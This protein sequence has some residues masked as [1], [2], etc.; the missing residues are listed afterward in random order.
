M[1]IIGPDHGHLI[2]DVEDQGQDQVTE[3][4]G[5]QNPERDKGHLK[6]HHKDLVKMAQKS[7]QS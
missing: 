5:G 2:G 7:K 4:I 1:Y 6:G 3:E